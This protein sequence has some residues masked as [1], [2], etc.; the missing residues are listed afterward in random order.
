MF[1]KPALASLAALTLVTACVQSNG[2]Y[3]RRSTGALAGGVIGGLVGAANSNGNRAPEILLGAGLGALAGGAIGDRLDRQAAE[4]RGS[5]GPQVGV[6]NTGSEIVVTMPQDILFA[7]N[8]ADL[9]SDLRSDLNAIAANLQRYPDSTV[10]VTGHTDSTGTAAYNQTLSERRADSVASVLITAGV[11]AR[12]VVA[13]GA[14]LT[15]PVAS[16]ETAAG[17][18]QNRRVEITIRP[19]A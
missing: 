6:V 1:Y 10:I 19:N 14:G 12:R 13:R 15:Q 8:S 18:A 16:N 17:R 7:T 4:L 9:R 5:L 11:P 3:D 2:E